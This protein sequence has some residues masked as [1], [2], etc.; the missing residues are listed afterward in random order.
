MYLSLPVSSL[1]QLLLKTSPATN[2]WISLDGASSSVKSRQ[3]YG[4]K[5][6]R[7]WDGMKTFKSG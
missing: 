1:N 4:S 3:T 2:H 5:P 6:G 7:H